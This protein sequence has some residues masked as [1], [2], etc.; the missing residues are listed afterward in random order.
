MVSYK[1]E[2]IENHKININNYVI[3]TNDKI[4][5][6][7]RYFEPRIEGIY[8][9]KIFINNMMEDCF[10]LFLIEEIF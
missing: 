4:Y 6:S 1:K 3:L 8:Y 2:E 7:K 5:K 10:G 9:V